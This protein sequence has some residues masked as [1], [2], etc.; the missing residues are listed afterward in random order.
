MI[1]SLCEIVPVALTDTKSENEMALQPTGTAEL[2][3]AGSATVG[4]PVASLHSRMFPIEPSVNPVPVTI[5]D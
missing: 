4:S 2:T 3:G 1:E 5:T